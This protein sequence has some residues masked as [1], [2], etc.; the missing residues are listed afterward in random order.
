MKLAIII[1][2]LSISVTAFA[3]Q[4]SVILKNGN[5]C[6]SGY[7]PDGEYCRPSSTAK[8]A[9]V[10]TGKWCPRGFTPDGNYCHRIS[11]KPSDVIPKSGKWCPQGYAPDGDY[12]RS[13]N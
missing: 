10:K 5:W 7:I 2:M 12:C 1:L 9:I 3:G 13:L 6:P 8:E 4:S 11:D